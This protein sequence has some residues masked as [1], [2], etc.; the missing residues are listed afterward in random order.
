MSYAIYRPMFTLLPPDREGKQFFAV[1]M[2]VA[3][4]LQATGPA[5]AMREAQEAGYPAPIV[6]PLKQEIRHA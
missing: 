1:E 6:G 5:A 3:R 2:K 4:L